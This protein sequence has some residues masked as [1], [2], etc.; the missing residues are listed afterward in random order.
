MIGGGEKAGSGIDKIRQGWA[1]QKWRLPLIREQDQARSGAGRPAD[2]QPAPRGVAGAAPA[3][4]RRRVRPARTRR[5]SRPSSRRTSKG[6][7]RTPRLRQFSDQHATDIT[8]LLQTLV[9]KG[10]LDKDGYGRCGHVPA[11]RAI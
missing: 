3:R 11:R 10:F 5:R 8:K 6:R 7:S 2:G 4:P 9:A 1:S